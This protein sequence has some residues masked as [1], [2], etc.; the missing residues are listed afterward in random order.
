MAKYRCVHKG[1]GLLV[2]G[3]GHPVRWRAMY[4]AENQA[5]YHLVALTRRY[6]ERR[7]CPGWRWPTCAST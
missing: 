5:S 2:L 6:H 3:S 7:R 4:L 1:G